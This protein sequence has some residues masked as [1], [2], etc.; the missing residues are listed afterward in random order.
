MNGSRF[1]NACCVAAVLLAG[2][3]TGGAGTATPAAMTS[4]SAARPVTD[5]RRVPVACSVPA[6][7]NSA[8]VLNGVGQYASAKDSPSLDVSAG[9]LISAWICQ[10]AAVPGGYRIV[11]KETGGTGD[12][13]DF[14]T[15][16][17]GTGNRL[18]L[19]AGATCVSGNTDYSLNQ[20]HFVAVSVTGSQ[21][22]FFL[23]GVADGGGDL[24]GPVAM[25]TLD[26]RIGA[27]HVGCGGG[28]GLVEFFNGVID[29]VTIRNTAAAAGGEQADDRGLAALWHF[30][31]GR[32][33]TAR[34]SSDNHNT[35]TLIN[36]ASWLSKH[37]DNG[38]EGDHRDNGR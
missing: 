6:R 29:E 36:G 16:G 33:T 26:L 10:K 12:G 22:S 1:L 34:D 31:E 2:C 18:R 30:D 24:G 3:S 9:F 17:Q 14:D 21:A 15:D 13:Y 35:G 11:D 7:G 20:W 4:G 27:P 37:D 32:G 25:N 38:D 8:L 23:D 28:C 19:C 5:A